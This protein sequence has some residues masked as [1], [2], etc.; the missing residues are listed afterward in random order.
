M[1]IV[2]Y[3]GIGKSSTAG[4]CCKYID[5]ESGNFWVDGKRDDDWYKVYV[6]IAEHLSQQGFTVFVSSHAV[7]REELKNTDERV[8]VIYPSLNLKDEWIE[9]L[10]VRYMSSQLEKDKKAYLNANEC[11]EKNIKDLANSGFETYEITSTD[12]RLIDV[13]LD[14]I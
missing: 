3:Q 13:L 5:L 6:N 2:G 10:Y 9:R 12:Y 14:I 11:Y 7:V 8:V 1:I 4:N